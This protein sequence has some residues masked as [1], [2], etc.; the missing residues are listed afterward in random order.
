M[1]EDIKAMKL[2]EKLHAIMSEMPT[3]TKNGKNAFHN[4]KYAKESDY[5][6][7]V[8][9]LLSKYRVLILPNVV[10]SNL[11]AEKDLTSIVMQYTIINADDA[12]DKM[13][14]SVPA[15]GADKSDKGVYKAITGAKKYMIANLL[16]V[17]TGDDPEED[18]ATPTQSTNKAPFKTYGG[19]GGFGKRKDG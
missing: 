8:R 18:V 9:P 15:Q 13:S 19:S 7:A 3:L 10:Q 12:D 5:V 16:M 6:E 4:Y 14:V 17:A 11:N 2:A 1:S